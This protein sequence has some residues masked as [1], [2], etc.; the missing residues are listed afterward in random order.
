MGRSRDAATRF[1][2]APIRHCIEP[3]APGQYSQAITPWL[4]TAGR[5]CCLGPMDVTGPLSLQDRP[6]MPFG[7]SAFWCHAQAV[8][9]MVGGGIST[10]RVADVFCD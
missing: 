4:Q 8:R 1:P 10:L 6:A 9:I 7:G 5:M 3:A 2:H